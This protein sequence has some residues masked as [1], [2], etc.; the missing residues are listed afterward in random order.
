MFRSRPWVR[1]SFSSSSSQR[2][3]STINNRLTRARRYQPAATVTTT[4]MRLSQKQSTETRPGAQVLHG[5]RSGGRHTM[6]PPRAETAL[7][8]PAH[9]STA[10]PGAQGHSE[11]LLWSWEDSP[12]IVSTISTTIQQLLLPLLRLPCSNEPTTVCKH[13]NIITSADSLAPWT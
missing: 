13:F 12:S 2:R 5:S 9:N 11:L 10:E 8:R 6:L 3:S 1:C 4:S 7:N